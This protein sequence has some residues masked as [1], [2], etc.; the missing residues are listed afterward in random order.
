MLSVVVWMRCN[1]LT[2]G[3][4]YMGN[5]HQV[6]D[7]IP[8]LPNIGINFLNW[9]CDCFL[10]KVRKLWRCL[11]SLDWRCSINADVYVFIMLINRGKI[12]LTNG[13]IVWEFPSLVIRF[14]PLS[15]FWFRNYFENP[16]FDLNQ[17][18]DSLEFLS[19]RK[20]RKQI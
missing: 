6:P 11:F 2:K 9:S 7:Q 18:Y 20:K 17:E 19:S 13:D 10:G 3:R 12:E 14:L 16:L 4:I 15:L 8:N 5:P 1:H